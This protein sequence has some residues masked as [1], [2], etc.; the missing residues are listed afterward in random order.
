MTQA[1]RRRS[2]QE[3]LMMNQFSGGGFSRFAQR[4][5][6]PSA[7]SR[8]IRD[9]VRELDADQPIT[10]MQPLVTTF[11]ATLFGDFARAQTVHWEAADDSPE[12]QLIFEDCAPDGDPRMPATPDFVLTLTGNSTQTSLING[13]FT[14]STIGT[15]ADSRSALH[16]DVEPAT[17]DQYRSLAVRDLRICDD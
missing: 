13:S 9:A 16:S 14:R 15:V 11:D 5:T 3:S 8:Q 12:L 6:A 4:A 7:I 2:F 10:E 1:P 17:E